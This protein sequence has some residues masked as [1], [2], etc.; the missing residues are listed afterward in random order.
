L[1]VDICV[2]KSRSQCWCYYVQ[3]RV[4]FPTWPVSAGLM[5]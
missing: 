2:I 5:L 1:P 4:V 3:Y